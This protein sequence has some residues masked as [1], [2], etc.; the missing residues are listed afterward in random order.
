MNNTSKDNSNE[1]TNLSQILNNSDS[2]EKTSIDFLLSLILRRKKIFIVTLI[3][4][5][6]F[7]LIR[8]TREKIYNPIFKGEF[9]ILIDDPIK[10]AS[11]SSFGEAQTMQL[12]Q[13]FMGVASPNLKQDIPTLRELLLSEL[14]LKDIAND[15][16]LDTKSLSER[17]DIK[18]DPKAEGILEII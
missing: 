13:N 12:A 15:Y 3:I 4:F 14:V 16:K 6:I 5:T 2:E 10:N 1:E 9:S 8:T 11:S 7:T 17:I 18:V